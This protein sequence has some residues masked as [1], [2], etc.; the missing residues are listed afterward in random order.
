MLAV[1]IDLFG[2]RR[3]MPWCMALLDTSTASF[4]QDRG[5]AH[6][7]WHGIGLS[8]S[9]NPESYSEGMFSWCGGPGC[10]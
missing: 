9:I 10:D 8:V 6:W 5:C 3:W 4:M 7:P 2:E 1:C